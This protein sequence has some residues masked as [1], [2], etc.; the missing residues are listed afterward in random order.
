MFVSMTGGVTRYSY[1]A[2][3]RVVSMT[4]ANGAKTT[5]AY[6]AVGNLVSQS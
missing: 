1:D 3:N 4:D 6:D 5:Y 2:L